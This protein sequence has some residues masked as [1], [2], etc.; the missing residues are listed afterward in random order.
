MQRNSKP[1]TWRAKG[2]SDTEDA[3]STFNGAMNSLSN[4]IPDPATARLWMCRPA[5][6]KLANFSTTG[7]FNL[8]FSA[9]FSIPNTAWQNAYGTTLI[10]TLGFISASIMLGDTCYGMIAG[11]LGYDVPFAY[12]LATQTLTLPSGVTAGNVPAS[13][14]TTGTWTPPTMAIIG[15]KIIVTHPGFNGAGTNWIGVINI[16]NPA[17]PVW[18]TTNLTGAI[19]FTTV[20]TAVAQFFNRAYFIHNAPAQPA[21]IFSDILAPTNAT[22]ANQILTFGDTVPLT[23]LAGLPL[24]NQLGGIIQSLMVFKGVTSINQITGDYALSTLS[25]NSLDIATGTLAPKSICATPKGLAFIAPDGLRVI[26]FTA[27]VSDPIGFD[28]SGVTLPFSSSIVPS[29][30]VAACN[31]SLYRVTTQNGNLPGSP[32]YEYW[33][34]FARQ[35]WSGP[36]TFP[37]NQILPWRGTFVCAPIAS[38]ASLWESDSIQNGTQLSWS[39][40][41]P[42]LPDTDEITN[43]AMTEGSI[44]LAFAPGGAVNVS[45]E[46]QNSAVIDTVS[47][48]ATGAPTI[49]GAFTWGAAVWGGAANAL[50]PQQLQWHFPITFARMSLQATGQSAGQVRVGAL[51]MRYQMLK[52][53]VN[54]GAAA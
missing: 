1:L 40:N 48:S 34:D 12:N 21:A 42:L 16:L 19:Q 50:A 36:H 45:V 32:N 47:I 14:S 43:N 29:R 6:T 28:G 37:M 22:N 46:D 41:T 44:D 13:P 10:G 49:W 4:L 3:S 2:L 27:Q 24:N 23:A 7:D 9:D 5:A 51:H 15:S 18:S 35:I 54:I 33:Y 31:G 26:N 20:P 25:Q 53:Y 17:A 39:W 52:Q 11:G 38:L 8:D 30:M